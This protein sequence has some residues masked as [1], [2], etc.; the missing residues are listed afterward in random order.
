VKALAFKGRD[1]QPLRR[2]LAPALV[3]VL[4]AALG[5]S[6]CGDEESSDERGPAGSSSRARA[7]DFPRPSSRS[8]RELTR[9]MPQGPELVPSVSLLEPGRNR[10]AFVLFDRGDR[11]IGGLDVALYLSQGLD[12]TVH[13]PF[14]ARYERIAAEGGEGGQT[15]SGAATTHSLYVTSVRLGDVSSYTAVAVSRLGGRWVASTPTQ[16]NVTRDSSVP[17]VGERAI[18]THNLAAALDTGQPILLLFA[19]PAQCHSRICGPVTDIARQVS[20]ELGGRVEFV[21]VEIYRNGDPSE[22]VR[23]EVRAWHLPT[24]PFAF[25]IDSRGRVAARLEGAF[26]PRELRVAARTALR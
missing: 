19:A 6:G 1:A 21:H 17:A 8:L 24:D 26:S 4:M 10:F 15:E 22:G 20:S 7:S 3:V 18:R 25:A 13:G 5:T 23:S 2:L 12:E 14:P 16:L 9:N 11:Q